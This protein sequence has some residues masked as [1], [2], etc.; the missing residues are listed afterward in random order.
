LNP[1]TFYYTAPS[2]NTERSVTSL[3]DTYKTWCPMTESNCRNLI[4]KQV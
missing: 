4:T 3:A 2:K 1:L